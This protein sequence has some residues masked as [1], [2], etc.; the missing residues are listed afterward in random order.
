M[1]QDPSHSIIRQLIAGPEA[2]KPEEK[3]DQPAPL[4]A[5]TQASIQPQPTASFSTPR[6]EVRQPAPRPATAVNSYLR[7][8]AENAPVAMA[9]FDKEMR[10]LFANQKWHEVFQL[11]KTEIVGRSQYDVFPSLHPGWRHV[12]ERAFTGQVVRSDRDTVNQAGQP[13]LYRWEVRPWRNLDTTVGGLMITCQCLDGMTSKEGATNIAP[14]MPEQVVV[15]DDGSLWSLPLPLLLLDA[16][17]TV[18]RAG[19]MAAEMFLPSGLV[20]GKTL[21]WQLFTGRSAGRE[22]RGPVLNALKSVTTSLEPSVLL[23][24]PLAPV[25]EAG[26]PPANWQLARLD[27]GMAGLPAGGVLA[28]GL[29]GIT[30]IAPPPGAAAPSG[31]EIQELQKTIQEA[32]EATGVAKVREARLRSV[33]ESIPCGLLLLDERG[34]AV[35]YNDT[36]RVLLG[37][38][39][40]EGQPVEEWLSATCRDQQ[41]RGEMVRVWRESVWRKQITRSISIIAQDG[42]FRDVELRPASLPGGGMIVVLRDVTNERRSEELLRSTEAKFRTMVHENPMPVVL[43]DRSGM[44]YE[45][46]SAAESMLGLT[47]AEL[48]R[49][50]LDEWFSKESLAGRIAALKEMTQRGDHHA[51]LQVELRD[52]GGN[53]LRKDMRI[54]AVPDAQGQPASTVHYFRDA[55]PEPEKKSIFTPVEEIPEAPSVPP[56]SLLLSTDAHGRVTQW[57]KTAAQ[58]FGIG[59]DE[60]LGRGLH[61][62]FR[63]SD[64]S[65]FYAEIAPLAAEGSSVPVAWN[66]YHPEHGQR[67]SSFIIVPL[68]PGTLSLSLMSENSAPVG[69]DSIRVREAAS[70]TFPAANLERERMLIGETHHRV[71]NH[72]QIITS[73]LNLQLSTL[74]H[75]DARE[76]LRS[77]QN[78]VRSIAELHQHLYDLAMGEAGGFAEFA[79]GLVSHLRECYQV[80]ENRVRL[81]LI[82]PAKPVPDEWLMP[83]ALSLNEMV[84]NAFKH[85]YRSGRTGRMRIELRLDEGSGEL[86]VS[87]DGAGLPQDFDDHCTS[88]LGLKI[89]R[90]FAGQLGGEVHVTSEPGRGA[91]FRLRFPL[92][93]P[94]DLPPN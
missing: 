43:A 46:N 24:L 3:S 31:I 70:T 38:P 57:S 71:K 47:R 50:A 85:A 4:A 9:I 84:S 83:L 62:I 77:S 79:S 90:V 11:E 55:A 27:P 21:F 29:S 40:S 52:R 2:N 42:L 91:D 37:P 72:L 41:H 5:P 13:V 22:I 15:P 76:A 66:F 23:E 8:L 61:T 64:A 18:C 35:F 67:K 48:R 86:S 94:G 56:G 26:S 28:I 74:G 33:L 80:D 82:V 88:G 59:P 12:Y 44:V 14:A 25:S 75:D 17:G 36:A 34:R 73:M 93:P 65:G 60:A 78:R 51:D 69:R 6:H 32:R 10:Y 20:E 87:D 89:M 68:E 1:G 7:I 39:A 53:V 54:A 92:R 45:A 81:E 16:S 30:S 49:M 19:S 63:P 58:C